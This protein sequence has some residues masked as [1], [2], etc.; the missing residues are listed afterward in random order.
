MQTLHL[1]PHQ[2]KFSNVLNTIDPYILLKYDHNLFFSSIAKNIKLGSLAV[3]SDV[4]EIPVNPDE[5]TMIFECWDYNP[6]DKP[7]R[8]NIIGS[9]CLSI[10]DIIESKNK[11]C[12]VNLFGKE[13]VPCGELLFEVEVSQE[14]ER[15][16]EFENENK[17]NLERQVEEENKRHEIGFNAP[18]N[19][20]VQSLIPENEKQI[21]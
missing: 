19:S 4:F 11:Y 15:P 14:H 9:S 1:K 7:E 8:R 16:K 10:H 6:E 17:I 12:R 3:W 20:G 2:G 5:K 18:L 13:T 21:N